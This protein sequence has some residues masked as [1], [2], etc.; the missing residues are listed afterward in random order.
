MINI[1]IDKITF[2]VLVQETQ[3][4]SLI[5]Y[6]PRALF[7]SVLRQSMPTSGQ[8]PF[9]TKTLIPL[10]EQSLDEQFFPGTCK[11]G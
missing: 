7:V 4:G 1:V 2:E 6:A 3:N 10:M 8:T 9:T 5:F 11:Y